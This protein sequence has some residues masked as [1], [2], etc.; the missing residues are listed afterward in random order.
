M[1]L[2]KFCIIDFNKVIHVSYNW[3]WLANY[4]NETISIDENYKTVEKFADEFIK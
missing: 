1:E 2:I 4:N 3:T